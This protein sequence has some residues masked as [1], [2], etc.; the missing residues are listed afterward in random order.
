[1]PGEADA[2]SYVKN[3]RFVP[4]SPGICVLNIVFTP[5]CEI[6][7]FPLAHVNPLYYNYKTGLL[8]TQ[9]CPIYIIYD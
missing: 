4:A 5:C 9:N 6:S 1:M 7:H 3:Y 2:D 8:Y